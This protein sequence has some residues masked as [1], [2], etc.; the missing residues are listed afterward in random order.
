MINP[1]HKFSSGEVSAVTQRLLLWSENCWIR[2]FLQ[3]CGNVLCDLRKNRA[4]A[5]LWKSQLMNKQV[6]KF[7]GLPATNGHKCIKAVSQWARLSSERGHVFLQ[8][9]HL[10]RKCCRTGETSSEALI[11][12]VLFVY[13]SF[14]ICRN[15]TWLEEASLFFRGQ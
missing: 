7:G 1:C 8:W 11:F 5:E 6:V 12:S 13:V 15:M 2:F 9:E 10:L 4:Q 3:I 14:R